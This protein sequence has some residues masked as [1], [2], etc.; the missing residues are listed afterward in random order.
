MI[1]RQLFDFSSSTYTYIIGNPETSNALII[2]PVKEHT[3]QYLTLLEQLGLKLTLCLDTHVHADHI[4]A[5]G[6]LKRKTGCQIAM[7]KDAA[8]SCVDTHLDD[9]QT[10][11]FADYKFTTLLT[12]GHTNDC[13]CFYGEGRVFTGD[14]LLIRSSGRTDFQSG[15]PIAA[16]NNITQ[17]LLTLPESTLVYP[18]HDYKGMTVST[19]GEEKKYNPRLQAKSAAEYAEIMNHLNLAKPKLIDIAVPANLQ[20]GL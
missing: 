7:S 1:F 4:T 5:S 8:T 19:I 10:I 11:P 12:P 3:K 17:K 18:G 15:D 2:D 20:C 9:G 14:T 13:A 6:E 16:Y